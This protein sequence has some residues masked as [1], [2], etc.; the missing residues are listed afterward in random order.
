MRLKHEVAMLLELCLLRRDTRRHW[1]G[2]SPCLNNGQSVG[3]D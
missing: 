2:L 3:I 1:N